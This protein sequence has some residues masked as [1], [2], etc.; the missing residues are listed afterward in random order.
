MSA[1]GVLD[2]DQDA[3]GHAL[4]AVLVTPP[5]FHTGLF[6][7]N[8]DGSFNYVHNGTDAL[9][10]AFTYR[11]VANGLQSNLATVTITITNV[12]EAPT[13]VADT[14]TTDEDTVLNAPAA[15]V[16]GNDTDP[17]LGDTKTVIG[18][19]APAGNVGTPILTAK[20][21]TLTVTANGAYTYDPTRSPASSRSARV[22]ATPTRSRR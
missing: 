20:G 21:A 13:A 15:G 6:T 22:R 12:N 19:N 1:P 11:A 9:S 14:G 2:G 17:D 16:L 5:S 4:T 18:V 7:L 3:E 8:A 10:D